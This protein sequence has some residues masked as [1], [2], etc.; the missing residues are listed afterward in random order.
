MNSKVHNS[1][2]LRSPSCVL[3]PDPR[4]HL[5]VRLDLKTGESHHRVIE[6]QY[7][8][9]ACFELNTAVPIDVATHFE[10]AKNLYLYAWFVYRFYPVAEQQA[11]ASLEFALRER[12]PDFVAAEKIKHPRGIEP[13]LKKLMDYAI[14]ENFVRN[15]DFSARE[16]WARRRAESRYRFQKIEEMRNAGIESWVEDEFE[17]VVTPEDFNYDWLH[18]FVKNIPSIRN[19]YAHG[20][21]TLKSNA[22]HVFEI[23]S[24]IINQLYPQ[25]S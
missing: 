6:D 5:F 17:I 7:K 10:T 2:K 23:V 12:F 9:I 18:I 19:E 24:E 25:T 11:L 13:G 16:H 14:K 21:P 1:D 8:A 15:E 22:R 20:S 3:E 4:T